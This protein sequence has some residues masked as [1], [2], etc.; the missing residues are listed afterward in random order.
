MFQWCA[1]GRRKQLKLFNSRLGH[2]NKC[3]QSEILK[4]LMFRILSRDSAVLMA[5]SC[6]VTDTSKRAEA[7]ALSWR[8]G[9]A[10]FTHA[11]PP[12]NWT[13]PRRSC[14][15]EH[16]C[17]D[18]LVLPAPSYKV[19]VMIWWSP[20]EQRR[21]TP[22]EFTVIMLM[23]FLQIAAAWCFFLLAC[24]LISTIFTKTCSISK[25]DKTIF[26]TS[27]TLYP[28]AKANRIFPVGSDTDNLFFR[29]F[30]QFMWKRLLSTKHKSNKHR[31]SCRQ[32]KIPQL[33][34]VSL[35]LLHLW[36]SPMLNQTFSGVS[37]ERRT[38]ENKP[39][40]SEP[41]SCSKNPEYFTVS[42]SIWPLGTARLNCSLT[43]AVSWNV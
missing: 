39:P 7:T 24:I 30:P 33:F 20:C 6:Y 1:S 29:H 31:I 38:E 27:C 37:E 40:R 34:S 36:L 28:S 16:E 5:L 11:L 26:I 21:S 19:C 22:W 25:D 2:Q 18:H 32:L 17:Q 12:W 15:C 4:G 35:L 23:T 41:S 3:W 13:S 8:L 9:W 43:A 42:R 10:A 14:R